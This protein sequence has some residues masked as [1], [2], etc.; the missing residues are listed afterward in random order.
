MSKGD[1]MRKKLKILIISVSILIIG[2]VCVLWLYLSSARLDI[3]TFSNDGRSIAEDSNHYVFNAIS[4]DSF[5]GKAEYNGEK[6]YVYQEKGKDIYEYII[7][8]GVDVG[9]DEE[10]I[11]SNK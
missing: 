11:N 10:F 2:F 1:E 5:R 8:M 7:I 4:N 6:Y 3:Y 9:V